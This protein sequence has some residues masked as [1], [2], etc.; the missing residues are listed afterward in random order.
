MEIELR[1]AVVTEYLVTSSGYY[2]TYN[3]YLIKKKV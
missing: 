1:A 2:V 3:G